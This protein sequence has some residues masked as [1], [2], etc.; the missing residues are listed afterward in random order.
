MAL[1]TL[2]ELFAYNLWAGERIFDAV[3]ALSALTILEVDH[4]GEIGVGQRA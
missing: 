1:S 4:P 2:Q 3:S